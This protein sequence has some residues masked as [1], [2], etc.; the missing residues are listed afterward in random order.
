V[1]DHQTPFLDLAEWAADTS[2][3][4]ERLCRI[5][6]DD[7]PLREVAATVPEDRTVENVFLA[8]VHCVLR[9]GVDHPLA[10]Y[11]PSAT[12]DPRPPDAALAPALRD[13]CRTYA[14]E[15]DPLLETR[16]TQTNEVR[17]A[18]ALYP[19]F[20]HVGA[21]TDGPLALV[22]IGPSAGLNLLWD[23][24][25]YEYHGVGEGTDAVRRV[26]RP[27]SPVTIQSAVEGGRPPLPADPPAVHSR[28]GIDLNPLDV[29]DDADAEWLQALTWPEHDDRRAR[30][31]A[32][33]DLARR[34]PPRL[35]EGDAVA[36]LPAVL[37]R[38]PADV[39]VVVYSTLVLYQVPDAI[40]EDLRE[41]IADRSGERPLHWLTGSHAFDDPGDGLELRWH[42][43][44]DGE[45]RSDPLARFQHHG[46]WIEWYGVDGA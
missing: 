43:S 20:A 24:F 32:V 45:L 10:E 37:D 21:R 8:A 31:S 11:Y 35:I 44:V 46:E 28:V 7:P 18:A 12:D 26:G 27:D 1:T 34:D 40:R 2:P 41:L 36:E 4:Y 15:L 42:R 6:A 13:F 39:P 38:I 19:A 23:R 22:E 3:L 25:D 29:T 30:L 17:R 33:I 5:V 14:D 16:R 9:R